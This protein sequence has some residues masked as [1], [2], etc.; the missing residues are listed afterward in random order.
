MTYLGYLQLDCR[1]LANANRV[2][3]HLN[4]LSAV[5]HDYSGGDCGCRHLRVGY[6]STWPGLTY[7]RDVTPWH[8]D[9]VPASDQFVGV[10]PMSITGL[11]SVPVQRDVV[12]LVCAGGAAPV[13]RD[14]VRVIDVEVLVVGCTNAGA[15]FGLQWLAC[16]LRQATV[17]GGTE[18]DF[19]AAH[20]EDST[21]PPAEL[22]AELFR[23][24]R[25]VVLTQAPTVTD[26]SGKGNGHP[27]RQASV[28]RVQFQLTA[29][30]PYVY[31]NPTMFQVS[32]NS[33][34]NLPI[35]WTH[36]P[37]CTT[38]EACELP[39]LFA[40]GCEPE[41]VI[42]RPAP[43][44]TCAGCLPLCEVEERRWVMEADPTDMCGDTTVSM[45][46][47]NTAETPLT[48]TFWWHQA[49]EYDNDVCSRFGSVTV[50]GLPQGATA[51]LDSIGGRP[52]AL[53]GGQRVR[54]VGV[55]STSSGAPWSSLLLD[56][57]LA[58]EL[59]AQV[60]PGASF[61]TTIASQGRDA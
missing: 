58:W 32:W 22:E 47:T 18:L 40:A 23:S 1:E 2:V 55:V 29:L 10:W 21:R 4:G 39:V 34:Q 3:D 48:G 8:N 11:D 46:I 7:D 5:Q 37:N 15:Q 16:Q 35:Q 14:T 6:D 54:Q 43:I 20:P 38:T 56:R 12:D 19:L 45:R 49:G 30:N 50:N 9:S 26:Y 25:S 51:V 59:V 53:I 17:R 33:V 24:V 28:L 60:E 61:Y 52:Y 31:E 57:G 41:R 42:V 27:N 13:H 44:P 36:Q